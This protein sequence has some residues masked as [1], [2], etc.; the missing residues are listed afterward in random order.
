MRFKHSGNWCGPGWSAGQYKDA[1]D[2]T[3]ED[4]NVPALSPFDEVCKEHDI[5]IHQAESDDDL[6]AAN[7]KF[8]TNASKLGISGKLIGWLVSKVGPQS[9]SDLQD[10]TQMTLRGTPDTE[11]KKKRV[12]RSL[13]DDLKEVSVE[14]DGTSMDNVEFQPPEPPQNAMKLMSDSS[15]NKMGQET[16]VLNIPPT[17]GLQETHTTILP[18]NI[19]FSVTAGDWGTPIIVKLK[20][21]SINSIFSGVNTPT[22]GGSFVKQ[23]AN[24]Y[25]PY[26]ST[27]LSW[28]NPLTSGLTP[29]GNNPSNYIPAWR[30]Y[31]TDIYEQYHVQACH[32]KLTMRNANSKA[33]CDWIVANTTE[34]YG[35]AGGNE[36]PTSTTLQES[37]TYKNIDHVVVSDFNNTREND[38]KIINKSYYPGQDKRNVKNDEDVKT[39]TGISSSPSLTENVVFMFWRGPMTTLDPSNLKMNCMLQVKYIVQFKDLKQQARYPATGIGSSLI[40][41]LPADALQ[42]YT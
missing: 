19:Y 10:S 41:T 5:D 16:K 7:E 2:L 27:T 25:L 29:M 28:P 39:W 26:D 36:L 15:G 31:Y 40:Q 12:K 18:V 34:S 17:Y 21:T 32:Y 23:A 3:E 4:Y 13:D 37:F 22:P 20:G 9:L 11:R 42:A 6:I 33:G 24:Y 38:I 14:A 1:R 30:D 8:Y 35:S